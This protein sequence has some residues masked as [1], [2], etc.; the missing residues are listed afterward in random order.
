[1]LSVRDISE[2]QLRVVPSQRAGRS[3][4]VPALVEHSFVTASITEERQV[5][6]ARERTMAL[7]LVATTDW[8]EMSWLIW[9]CALAASSAEHRSNRCS[10]RPIQSRHSF[11][12]TLPSPNA[13]RSTQAGEAVKNAGAHLRTQQVNA[14]YWF[15]GAQELATV[16]ASVFF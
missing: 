2:W 6:M 8:S 13:F 1:M 4:L 9:D 7:T 12:H 14:F 15:Q 3:T 11:C 10:S 5:R 16:S